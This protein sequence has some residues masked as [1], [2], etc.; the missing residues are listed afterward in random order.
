MFLH[1]DSIYMYFASHC[2]IPHRLK[3][4][5]IDDSPLRENHDI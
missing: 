2:Y 1:N 3:F 4:E 5:K